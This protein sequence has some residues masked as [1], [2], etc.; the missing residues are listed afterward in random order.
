M[1][2]ARSLT[3][4][5]SARL[6]VP[7]EIHLPDLISSEIQVSRSEARRLIQQGGVKHEDSE[8]ELHYLHLL[9]YDRRHL[10]GKTITVGRKR[11]FVVGGGAS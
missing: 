4:S 10:E 8:G 1:R 5:Q 3:N 7:D 2:S 11:S 6:P 9:D